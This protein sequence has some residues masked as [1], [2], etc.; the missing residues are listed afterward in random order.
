M[1]PGEFAAHNALA[2]VVVVVVKYGAWLA[3]AAIF[4]ADRYTAVNA[5][6]ARRLALVTARF[7]A[8][9]PDCHRC[10]AVKAFLRRVAGGHRWRYF[11]YFFRKTGRMTS[12]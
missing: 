5:G 2:L 8:Q 7:A 1:P 10:A 4:V 9:R 3:P 12:K 11:R 6:R